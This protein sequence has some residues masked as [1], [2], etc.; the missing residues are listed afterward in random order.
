[1]RHFL[2]FILILCSALQLQASVPVKYQSYMALVDSALQHEHEYVGELESQIMVLRN[3]LQSAANDEQSY[4]LCNLLSQKYYYLNSDSALYY[5]N[6]KHDLAERNQR[7]DWYNEF[8]LA[9][10]NLY[11]QI[12][13][14][15]RGAEDL[16]E[17]N[18]QE[19][20]DG[21]KA[22]Y[23]SMLIFQETQQNRLSGTQGQGATTTQ[24]GDSIRKYAEA[25]N[26]MVRYWGMFFSDRG[27][28]RMERLIAAITQTYEKL[29][30]EQSPISGRAAFM[31]AANYRQTGDNDRWMEYLCRSAADNIRFVNRDHSALLE[32]ISYLIE[33][34][35]VSRAYRYMDY[36]MDV[37]QEYPDNV[38][39]T[40]ISQYMEQIYTATQRITE[41]Q[42][43]TTH[44]YLLALMGASGVLL[45]AFLLLMWLLR[46]QSRQQRVIEN[47]NEQLNQNI[48]ELQETQRQL[49]ASNEQ[50]LEMNNELGEAN[51]IKE[52][53][54]GSLFST[55]SEYINKLDSFRLE[56]NRKLKAGQVEDVIRQTRSDNSKTRDEVKELNKKFD[57]T[58]LSIYPDFVTDFQ[59]LLDDE[60]LLSSPKNGLNTELRIYALV[61]LGISSS[62][63]IA[64]LLHLSPQT[65][66]NA[67]QKVR[68]H[69]LQPC[70]TAED[71]AA[72]VQA[73]GRGKIRMN[74]E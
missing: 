39:S 72:L 42:Q 47:T 21:D 28:G 50:V 56:I 36:I 64:D 13:L 58:F 14:L 57:S 35:D 31:A 6:R 65:V 9:R 7:K 48:A 2:L 27:E 44:Q 73:I 70:A 23:Y 52:Q 29:H 12:G 11:T 53:Y 33:Q 15:S 16:A 71:F 74:E 3:Q 25:G 30:Q 63:K 8:L 32:L 22:Q 54:I 18:P 24:L 61:W 49:E 55:C 19:L 41:R 51:Y 17:I 60:E 5:L 66:Y 68:S 10:G 45:I 20:A 62:V 43:Q 1:M 38:R 40:Q 37:Q 69:S 67:R 59:S 46:K 4:V 34:D 26:D